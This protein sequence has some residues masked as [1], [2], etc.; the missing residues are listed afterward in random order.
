VEHKFSLELNRS[1]TGMAA[2]REL[3]TVPC[4]GLPG[5]IAPSITNWNLKMMWDP[6]IAFSVG[7]VLYS[8]LILF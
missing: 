4:P 7:W 1:S 5:S 3:W 2:G 6:E 8:K